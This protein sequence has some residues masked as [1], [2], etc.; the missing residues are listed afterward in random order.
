M[1]ERL[2]SELLGT[3]ATNNFQIVTMT[4]RGLVPTVCKWR[5]YSLI[6][7]AVILGN[8]VCSVQGMWSKQSG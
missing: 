7:T 6:I 2:W 1:D 4:D 5:Y 3:V 8:I